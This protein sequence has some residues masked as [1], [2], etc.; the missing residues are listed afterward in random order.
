MKKKVIAVFDIGKTNKKFLLF[1]HQFQ[2]VY[3]EEE[4]FPEISDEDGFACDDAAR[5]EKW[6]YGTL[7]SFMKNSEYKLTA[8]NFTTY[9]ATLVYLSENGKRLTPFYNYLKPVESLLFEPLYQKK[10]GK[11]EFCRRTASPAL[12]MLNSGLQIYWLKLKKNTIY[13]QVKSVLHLP[14][15]FS[16]L[17][18]RRFISELTSIGCHTA[19]WDFDKNQYHAWLDEEG[20]QLPEIVS[21]RTAFETEFANGKIKIGV[22]IHDS[23]ASLVPYL[24]N[25]AD[26]FIL[27]STGTWC[28]TM[29][30]FNEEPLT[31]EQL[32]NDCLCYLS[33]HQKPVKSSRLFLGPLFEK[34]VQ[35]IEQHFSKEPNSYRDVNTDDNLLKSILVGGERMFFSQSISE[36]YL[37]TSVNLDS[38]ENF[39]Q[40]Y[41]QLVFDIAKLCETSVRLILPRKDESKIIYVSGGFSRNNLFVNML[42]NI[43]SNKIVFT[44]KIDNASALGAALMVASQSGDNPQIDLGL[45]KYFPF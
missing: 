8:L 20:I 6:I 28:I 2:V 42:A 30:P 27:M 43:F 12:E 29:N 19:M 26:P 41:H 13:N 34:N 39:E 40:A 7:D 21:N 23:S 31:T 37:D 45:K 10:G 35:R 44:S 16:F 17:F 38:F 5:I 15:Y 33:V 36:N 4:I 9:G 11:T 24:D 18:T 14:Q 22:G 1:N 25:S 32:K 3:Q